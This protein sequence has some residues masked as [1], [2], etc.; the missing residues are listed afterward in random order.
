VFFA[1]FIFLTAFNAFNART[2]KL[3]IFNHI[4]ENRGFVLVISLIFVVQ[5]TFTYLGG[6]FLRTVALTL[7][8]WVMVIAASMVIIPFDVIR[9]LVLKSLFGHGQA[10]VHSVDKT[11]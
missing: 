11:N 5:V 9:K 6:S 3:N 8:E 1:F 7:E 2:P 10:T 4:L